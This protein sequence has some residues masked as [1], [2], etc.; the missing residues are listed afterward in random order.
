M[1]REWRGWTLVDSAGR[2]VT[3]GVHDPEP[4]TFARKR[5]AESAKGSDTMRVVPC[6]V[7]ALSRVARGRK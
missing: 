1:K 5:D 3:A 4:F 2:I 6:K 7:I